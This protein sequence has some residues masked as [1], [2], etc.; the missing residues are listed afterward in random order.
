ME[1]KNKKTRSV[2]N[3]EGSLYKSEKLNCWIYQYYDTSGKRQTMKQRKNETSKDFKTRVTEIKNSLNNGTYIESNSI[4]VYELAIE[5]NENKLKRNKI[6][7]ATYYRN[8][9]SLKVIENSKIKNMQVQKITS[10][11]IQDFMDTLISYANST[12]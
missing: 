3:G 12:I 7:P 4:T 11:Q 5:I 6:T 1:R 2:G 10:T 8:L 9:Q